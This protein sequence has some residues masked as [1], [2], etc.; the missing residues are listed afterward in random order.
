[1]KG[2][3]LN[4]VLVIKLDRNHHSKLNFV[5]VIKL[6]RNHHSKLNFVLV[7]KLN[8]NHHSK[9]NKNGR[10]GRNQILSRNISN[11]KSSCKGNTIYYVKEKLNCSGSSKGEK[12]ATEA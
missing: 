9:L 7:V 3:K 12:K 1:M 11:R 5:L 8:R 6:N 10:N 2:N 4:F